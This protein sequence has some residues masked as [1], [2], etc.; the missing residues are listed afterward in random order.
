MGNQEKDD[1]ARG[2]NYEWMTIGPDHV[3]SVPNVIDCIMVPRALGVLSSLFP[4]LK[5]LC[6]VRSI[7]TTKLKH[8]V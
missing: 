5:G 2:L 8:F 4:L 3:V 6:K 7:Y 1:H